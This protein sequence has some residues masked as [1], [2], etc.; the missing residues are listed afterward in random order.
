MASLSEM[1]MSMKE[2]LVKPNTHKWGLYNG[3]RVNVCVCVCV[4]VHMCFG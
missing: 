1:Q 3:I 4:C 2:D